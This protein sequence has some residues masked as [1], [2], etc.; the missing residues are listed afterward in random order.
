MMIRPPR[1]D[2]RNNPVEGGGRSSRDVQWASAPNRAHY[3]RCPHELVVKEDRE[4]VSHVALCCRR[5]TI[6]GLRFQ[7]YSNGDHRRQVFDPVRVRL[8]DVRI[9]DEGRVVNEESRVGYRSALGKTWGRGRPRNP[10][11]DNGTSRARRLR[12]RLTGQ[13]K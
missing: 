5:D 10:Q 11:L 9:R 7:S 13:G 12:H 2:S 6:I 4:S 8:Y 1:C 3:W